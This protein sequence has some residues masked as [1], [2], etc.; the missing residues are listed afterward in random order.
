[1]PMPNESGIK[2]RNVRDDDSVADIAK[3][4]H[5]TDQYIYPQIC[6]NPTDER[7]IE[8]I[9]LCLNQEGNLFYKKNL[10][11][12]EIH[13][14]IC[15]AF[16]VIQGGKE[17]VSDCHDAG[18]CNTT[19]YLKVK[20]GYFEPLLRE[21]LSVCGNTLTNICVLP[22]FRRMHIGQ[23]LIE[24]CIEV[25]GNLDIYLD[26]L[27][28]N[29]AAIDLYKKNGFVAINN[30]DGFGNGSTVPCYYMVRR[31]EPLLSMINK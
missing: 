13:A 18:I 12:A 6:E 29:D 8:Y 16:C 25:F 17:Y 28:E 30:Y 22:E 10:V 20:K 24:K 15:G 23:L 11:V 1:M 31:A 4:I 5:L 14:R 9:G 7:W 2:I 3:C 19:G 21:N 26:V 27:S